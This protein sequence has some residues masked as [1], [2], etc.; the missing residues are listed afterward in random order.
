MTQQLDRQDDQPDEG[1]TVAVEHIGGIDSCRVELADGVTVLTGRNATNR[2]SLLRAL[3][4]VLGG[5]SAT[6]KSDADAGRVELTVGERTYRREYAR[7]GDTVAASGEPYSDQADLVDLFV[8]VLESNAARRAV[9]R[10]GDLRE[11]LMQPVDTAAIERRIHELREERRR[12]AD[13]LEASRQRR[14]RLPELEARKS[15][16]E[17]DLAAVEDRLE[18]LRAEVADAETALAGASAPVEELETARQELRERRE[19]IDVVTAE[20]DALRETV[21]ELSAELAELPDYGPDAAEELEAELETVR[22]RKGRL[23]EQIASLSAVLEFNEDLLAGEALPAG[24]ALDGTPVDG[25]APETAQQLH[26]WTCGSQVDRGSVEDRLDDLR[27]VVDELRRERAE[28][29]ERAAD[30]EEERTHVDRVVDRR[31][32]IEHELETSRE[33]LE[34][35]EGKLA[36]LETEADELAERVESLEAAVAESDAVDDDALLETYEAVSEVR[37]ERHRLEAELDEVEEDIAAIEATPDPAAL[38]ARLD[39]V[40]ADLERERTRVDELEAGAVEAFND[41]MADLLDV[42]EYA[43]LARVWIER[44]TADGPSET[45]FELHIVRETDDG[46]AY[47][48]RLQHLSESERA[49]VG[50]VVALAGYLTHEVA[51]EVPFM[52]LDSLEAI[53][54]PRI[55]HLVAYFARRVPYLVVAMLPED[56]AALP[57]SY[58][59]VPADELRA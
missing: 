14:G 55:E 51:S 34:A 37:Y 50:L 8:T 41:H 7:K 35:R 48:D 57:D 20:R 13:D 23:D 15:E 40:T 28:L 21:D 42:L 47:E 25:L 1:C 54:A 16:L 43:N 30:F 29:A 46:S 44:K 24:V 11:V 39:E 26:C 2:T 12:I 27:S 18:A 6:L 5:E 22:D 59:R 19:R 38:E 36:D 4:G 33:K 9:E 3:N 58:E 53:D 10:D 31:R 49:V 56:A 52:L 45:T 32:E 17:A